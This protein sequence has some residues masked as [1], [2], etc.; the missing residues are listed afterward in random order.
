MIETSLGRD[1]G[2]AVPII[3]ISPS[4]LSTSDV[5]S[6]TPLTISL[7]VVGLTSWTPFL[8][9]GHPLPLFSLFWAL[10]T[11]LPQRLTIIELTRRFISTFEQYSWALLLPVADSTTTPDW[12]VVSRI[13]LGIAPARYH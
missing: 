8:D 2:N 13:L 1:P 7:V 3:L 5:L 6:P 4:P 10:T 11:R 12:L 9:P